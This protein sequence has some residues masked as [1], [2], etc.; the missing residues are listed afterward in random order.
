M[1]RKNNVSPAMAEA[2]PLQSWT[3]PRM[4]RLATSAAAFGQPTTNPDSEGFS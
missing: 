1:T 3:A 2:A 4:R